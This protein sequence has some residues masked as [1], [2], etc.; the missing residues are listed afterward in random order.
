MPGREEILIDDDVDIIT[1]MEPVMKPPRINIKSPVVD[2]ES[3]TDSKVAIKSEGL[4]SVRSNLS[5][6][7][8]KRDKFGQ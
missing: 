4:N 1:F 7:Q 8:F 6:R 2:E 5:Y 3:K